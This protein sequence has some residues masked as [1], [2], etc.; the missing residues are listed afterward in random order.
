MIRRFCIGLLDKFDVEPIIMSRNR[1]RHRLFFGFH[2]FFFLLVC[3]WSLAVLDLIIRLFQKA[4]C[5]LETPRIC[6]RLIRFSFCSCW[7]LLL[8]LLIL[9]LFR[10]IFVYYIQLRINLGHRLRRQRHHHD[11]LEDLWIINLEELLDALVSHVTHL[12]WL[13]D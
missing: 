3:L 7:Y 13:L 4:H 1:L 2:N 10:L 9:I 5:C 11:L 6:C 8:D 12:P